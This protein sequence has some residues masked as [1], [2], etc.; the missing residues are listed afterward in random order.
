VAQK[1]LK[2]GSGRGK[3][4]PSREAQQLATEDGR[5][6][7]EAQRLATDQPLREKPRINVS[8]SSLKE[9][10]RFDDGGRSLRGEKGSVQMSAIQRTSVQ[11]MSAGATPGRSPYGTGMTLHSIPASQSNCKPITSSASCSDGYH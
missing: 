8:R 10:H 3:G 5:P 6:S 4:R 1:A 7:R 9:V 11:Q 2:E